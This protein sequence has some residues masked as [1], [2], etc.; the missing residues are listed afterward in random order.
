RAAH[1]VVIKKTRRRL[2]PIDLRSAPLCSTFVRGLGFGIDLI[3]YGI[4]LLLF[5]SAMN[6]AKEGAFAF[7]GKLFLLLGGSYF[8][9]FEFLTSTTPGKL[10]LGRRAVLENG[11]PLD[12]TAAIVRNIV[13]PLDLILGYPLLALT[14]RKQRL[15]DL[16]ADTLVVK[17]AHN[18][19]GAVSLAC[20]AMVLLCLA[21]LSSRNPDRK[22]FHPYLKLPERSATVPTSPAKTGAATPSIPATPSPAAPTGPNAPGFPAIPGAVTPPAPTVAA[23]PIA[24]SA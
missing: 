1:T 16:I 23:P 2:I 14:R 12:A 3:L 10:L 15:G 22:W 18:R 24:R 6:P 19:N 21:Y 20:L 9:I 4:F 8:M 7:M 11:E 13:R 17:K 5:L